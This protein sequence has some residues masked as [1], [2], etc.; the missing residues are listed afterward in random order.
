MRQALKLQKFHRSL[1][2][3]DEFACNMTF[4]MTARMTTIVTL[5]ALCGV[6]RCWGLTT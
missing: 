4:S 1:R 6:T 5:Q 2:D 3:Q